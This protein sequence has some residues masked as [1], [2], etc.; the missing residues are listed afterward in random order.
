[1]NNE[2]ND[3]GD[4]CHS[5]WDLE[6]SVGVRWGGDGTPWQQVKCWLLG[7]VASLI[8][9]GNQN[10][11]TQKKS[12]I[13]HKCSDGVNKGYLIAEGNKSDQVILTFLAIH[14]IHVIVSVLNKAT[15]DKR[16]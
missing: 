13:Q 2:V 10:L 3:I 9:S 1:M 5:T 15:K 7:C 16:K 14:L 8:G 6:A 4:C 11:H 12:C